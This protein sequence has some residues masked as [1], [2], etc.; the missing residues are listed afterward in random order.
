[1]RHCE[2]SEAIHVFTGSK[3]V[4]FAALATTVGQ[5]FA[6]R[7]ADSSE[8]FPSSAPAAGTLPICGF[9]QLTT[10]FIP[11]HLRC[12]L[13]PIAFYQFSGPLECVT[14]GSVIADADNDIPMERAC[15]G[16]TRRL[17]C[18]AHR[19]GQLVGMVVHRH[20]SL[21][22]GRSNPI[23]PALLERT[24][25]WPPAFP[26]PALKPAPVCRIS[27]SDEFGH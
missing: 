25:R 24:R 18:V 9:A 20:Q 23:C 26:L 16:G 17:Q 13:C 15:G 6:Y 7:G 12:P 21:F 3:M 4:C 10:E 22:Y 11:E 19:R 2:A 14:F 27:P 1:M 5:S 8:K